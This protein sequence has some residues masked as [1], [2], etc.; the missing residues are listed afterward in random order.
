MKGTI[1]HEGEQTVEITVDDE[2]RTYAVDFIA[3]AECQFQRGRFS[4]PPEDCYPDD[5]EC[6][7][8]E[9]KITRITNEEG[10]EVKDAS[11]AA[12]CRANLDEDQIADE[13]W[14]AFMEPQD[15][16]PPD[17]D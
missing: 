13:C 16:E 8:T 1:H 2:P 6:D 15:E 9:I 12:I 11:I 14:E 17:N 3:T 7:V 5:G 4:G 10:E